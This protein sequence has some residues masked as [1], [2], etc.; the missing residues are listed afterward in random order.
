MEAPGRLRHPS[1]GKRV[2]EQ[3]TPGK[4]SLKSPD[5]SSL[6]RTLGRAAAGHSLSRCADHAG[7]HLLYRYAR[8]VSIAKAVPQVK[9]K[10]L[11]H[12]K[13]GDNQHDAPPGCDRQMQ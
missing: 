2:I 11:K 7:S 3:Q 9:V 8:F 1:E 12:A 10:S 4:R 13:E 6:S 5:L